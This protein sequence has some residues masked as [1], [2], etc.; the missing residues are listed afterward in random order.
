MGL[1]TEWLNSEDYA[2]GRR[3]EI[4]VKFGNNGRPVVSKLLKPFGVLWGTS[5]V[6]SN[7][8]DMSGYAFEGKRRNSLAIFVAFLASEFT[9]VCFWLG[10]GC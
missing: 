1:G 6:E 4:Q 8:I 9:I 3:N 5:Q 7:S 2:S 10:A